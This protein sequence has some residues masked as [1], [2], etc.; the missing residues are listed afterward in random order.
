M[1]RLFLFVPAVQ[2]ILP[3][4][5]APSS[6]AS[7]STVDVAFTI[8]LGVLASNLFRLVSSTRCMMHTIV[9]CVCCL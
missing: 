2:T 6:G 7:S 3:V 8:A 9:G 4:P 1:Q 5:T